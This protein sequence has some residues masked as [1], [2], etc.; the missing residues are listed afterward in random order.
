MEEGL[1]GPGI[2]LTRN[3][4]LDALEELDDLEELDE[5]ARPGAG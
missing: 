5:P 1:E 4:I 3:F 2:P